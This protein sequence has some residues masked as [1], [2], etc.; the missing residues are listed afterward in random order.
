[1]VNA[2]TEGGIVNPEPCGC[3][4]HGHAFA[5]SELT[6]RRGEDGRGEILR[7]FIAVPGGFEVAS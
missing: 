5:A 3:C 4:K 1:V 6:V 7:K 2:E